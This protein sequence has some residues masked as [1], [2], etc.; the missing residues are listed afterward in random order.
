[1]NDGPQIEYG[2]ESPGMT[3]PTPNI[4]AVAP[5]GVSVYAVVARP[6]Y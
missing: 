4:V 5:V 6:G 2:S 1:V 3:E